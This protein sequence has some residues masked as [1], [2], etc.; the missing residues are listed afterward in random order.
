LD[1]ALQTEQTSRELRLKFT[2]VVPVYNDGYLV[3]P[4]CAEFDK[5]MRS[6]FQTDKLEEHCELIF[7]DDGSKNNTLASLTA[8]IEQYKY[9]R[10]IELSRNFGQHIAIACGFREARGE[11]IGRM[12][13]D[14]QDHPEDLPRML[15]S[16]QTENVDMVIGIYKE[17]RH[18]A[19]NKLTAYLYFRLFNIFTGLTVPQ[20]TAPLRIMNRSYIDAYNTLQEKSRF[21]QGLDEWFGFKKKYLL[22][23]HHKREDGKSSYNLFSRWALAIDGVLSFSDKPLKLI[24]YAGAVAAIFGFIVSI[25]LVSMRLVYNIYV[26]GY[27]SLIT[28]ILVCFGIQIMCIGITGLYI[29]RILRETQN[30]PLYVIRGKYPQ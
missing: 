12:N 27:V 16:F 20:N 29:G 5:A 30:R 19:L 8:M 18:S 15:T 2:M 9:V 17:R 13:I 3:E 11:L 25:A 22:I 26:P 28:V 21:P 4:Y 14:M 23:E 7:V 10:V 6:H 24:L 1:Q